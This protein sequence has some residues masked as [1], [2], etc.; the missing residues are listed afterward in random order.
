M[1]GQNVNRS[2]WLVY[3]VAIAGAFLIMAA[4]VWVMSHYTRPAPV[5]VTRVEDRR[6]A[7]AE[8][9]AA[10]ADALRNYG[11][12]DPG[13]G[14]VR[15]PIVRAMEITLQEYQHPAAARSNLVA[16]AEHAAAQPP[17]P[18]EQPSQYE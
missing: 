14:I 12:A 9:R 17:K 13:K 11:W 7:L 15:L 4:L 10:E 2:S 16:R 6:K 18:P 3:S 5:G 1:N 8:I